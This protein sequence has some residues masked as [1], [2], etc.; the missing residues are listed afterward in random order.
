M[1]WRQGGKKE[2]DPTMGPC[3]FRAVAVF[4]NA[5]NAV[6]TGEAASYA[7]RLNFQ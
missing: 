4:A 7:A 6:K 5:A 3:G 1:R 2:R